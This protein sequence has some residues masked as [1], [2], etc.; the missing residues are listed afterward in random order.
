MIRFN[1]DIAKQKPNN[2]QRQETY[3][4]FCEREHLSHIIEMK[5]SIIWLKNKYQV[6]EDS[7]QTLIIE[8]DQC[9][10][11]LSVYPK[12]HLHTLFLF[13]IE[14]WRQMEQCGKYK[15]VML[16]KNHGP[17]SGGSIR[18]PHL[19]IIGLK[20][21]DYRQHTTRENFE[22]ILIEEKNGVEFNVST[23]PRVGFTEF[24]VLVPVPSETSIKVMAEFVQKCVHYMLNMRQW[25]SYNL[26][27][28]EYSGA[29]YVK[30]VP[31]Y[32]TSPLFVG[33]S[34]P[35]VLNNIE[36]FADELRSYP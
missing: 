10:S 12:D 11:E 17:Q 27:F 2:V 28:Y 3:C 22:G 8:T 35:Q 20:H 26:F 25:Q 29:L 14:K 19:H 18:H 4:P 34:I 9:D 7:Y 24:N 23:K 32:V 36:Y 6:L 13:T 1:I 21:M 30:A 15:S 5:D 33:Y 16:Y 31:R